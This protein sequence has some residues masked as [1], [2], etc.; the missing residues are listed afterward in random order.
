MADGILYYL[1]AD[2]K[3]RIVTGKDITDINADITD[4][5][6]GSLVAKLDGKQNFKELY[7]NMKFDFIVPHSMY[8][9]DYITL[10][11][12]KRSKV[13]EA[14]KAQLQS[15]YKNYNDLVF[16]KTEISGGKTVTFRVIF[17]RRSLISDIEAAFAEI[18]INIDRFIPCGEALFEGAVKLNSAVKKHPCVVLD[19]GEKES[20]LAAYGNDVLLGGMPIPFGMNALSDNKV[21]Y[22]RQLFHRDSSEL[23]V[24]NAKERAKSTKLTMAINF[25][26]EEIDDSIPDEDEII[27]ENPALPDLTVAG[28]DIINTQD[29]LDDNSAYDEHIE[30]K[31][32]YKSAVRTLPKFMQRETPETADGF[33]LENFRMF[34]KR[35]LMLIR[36]MSLTAY[37]PKIENIFIAIPQEYGFVISKMRSENPSYKWDIIKKAEEELTVLGTFKSAN[38]KVVV[39]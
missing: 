26:Q 9:V 11:N 18:G 22:E 3:F 14:Y 16:Q 5:R 36:D 34:E 21:I 20:Y 2:G 15:F 24:I 19:I 8:G 39:F 30:V 29:D 10:P 33:V 6:E 27:E 17:M 32:L 37:Y 12:I 35:L 31:T 23:L 28:T 1:P 38:T 7:L 13:E 25:E 4:L